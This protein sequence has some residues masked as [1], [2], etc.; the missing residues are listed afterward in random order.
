MRERDGRERE[1]R[2]RWYR[3]GGCNGRWLAGVVVVAHVE[4][5]NL[6]HW[7]FLS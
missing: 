6:L 2:E 4:R 5:E 7:T 3:V 1:E